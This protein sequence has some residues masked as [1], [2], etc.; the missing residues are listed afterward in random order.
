MIVVEV[1]VVADLVVKELF[2]RGGEALALRDGAVG[3]VGEVGRVDEAG[4]NIFA[5]VF[6]VFVVVAIGFGLCGDLWV[7]FGDLADVGGFCGGVEAFYDEIAVG[8]EV[9]N[10]LWGQGRGH[11]GAPFVDVCFCWRGLALLG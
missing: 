9:V 10:L 7:G 11:C 8:L 3:V 4:V 5:G 1:V 2:E 6:A